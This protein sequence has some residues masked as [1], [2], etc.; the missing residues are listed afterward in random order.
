MAK[1]TAVCLSSTLQKT[2]TFKRFTQ[3]QVNRS[4]T[5]EIHASGKAVNSA[6]VL[7]Q[8]EK[9]FCEVV[10]PL[11][12]RNAARFMELAERDGLV[13]HGIMIPGFTRECWTLLDRERHGTTELVVSE[14]VLKDDVSLQTENLLA[15]VAGCLEH[16][17]ALLLAG[18]RP[19]IWPEDLSAE[20]CKMAYDAGKLVMA[21]FWGPDLQR[22]L[23]LCTPQIIKINEEEF[24][25]T[26]GYSFPQN[27]EMLQQL[28]SE[29]SRKLSD[30]IVV[31]RGKH[32]TFAA[33]KGTIYTEPV[34]EVTVVNSTA[35]GDSFSAGFLYEYLK[36]GRMQESLFKGTWCAARN[37][38]RVCPGSII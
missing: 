23:K 19:G 30:I 6:R 24:C 22:T 5:Y 15:A 38:E 12:E 16:C 2:I 28:I 36:T 3:E 35:C 26:F 21:D 20:I 17:E 8:L 27:E 1:V 10:C 33:E 13:I 9:G 4:E 37:A 29:E 11:G 18:S 25:G 34:H 14:P 31:T 7:N 32:S